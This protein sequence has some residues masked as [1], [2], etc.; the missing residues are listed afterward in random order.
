MNKFKCLFIAVNNLKQLNLASKIEEI[1]HNKRK[2]VDLGAEKRSYCVEKKPRVAHFFHAF[3]IFFS[4]FILFLRT[5]FPIFVAYKRKKI[6]LKFYSL[7]EILK[8]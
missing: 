4:M 6:S 5:E 1:K 8:F 2:I 7:L 3:C